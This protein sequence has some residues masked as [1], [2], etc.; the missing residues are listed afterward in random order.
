MWHAAYPKETAVGKLT[1]R[2][3]W[4]TWVTWANIHWP[5]AW[6]VRSSNQ[7]IAKRLCLSATMELF[8]DLSSTPSLAKGHLHNDNCSTYVY[9]VNIWSL[10]DRIYIYIYIIYIWYI[11]IYLFI[12]Y[13]KRICYIYI[14]IIIYTYVYTSKKKRLRLKVTAY[15]WSYAHPN[16]GRCPQCPCSIMPPSFRKEGGSSMSKRLQP[17]FKEFSVLLFNPETISATFLGTSSVFQGSSHATL[18]KSNM[19]MENYP[20][21]DD[22]SIY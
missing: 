9:A 21:A 15:M 14:Y 1:T 7:I 3:I 8:W 2:A 4:A 6:P 12:Y 16:K 17:W 13:F 22:L 10:L 19:A 5:W 18:W 20:Y 11:Y